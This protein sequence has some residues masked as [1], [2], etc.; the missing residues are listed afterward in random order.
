[1]E[2]FG[3]TGGLSSERC[4]IDASGDERRKKK[5]GQ[6]VAYVQSIANG[7]KTKKNSR[8][9]ADVGEKRFALFLSANR[10]G[11]SVTNQLGLTDDVDDYGLSETYFVGCSVDYYQYGEGSHGGG[12]QDVF[13]DILSSI[14]PAQL[15]RE[16]I[17]LLLIATNR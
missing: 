4:E 10:G 11:T 3:R 13:L 5:K 8:W 1:M 9:A 15:W 17:L 7:D 6:P 16:I 14:L 2:L 12:R